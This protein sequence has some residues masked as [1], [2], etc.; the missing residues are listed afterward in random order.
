MSSAEAGL[1]ASHRRVLLEVARRSV[2]HG[3]RERRPLPVDPGA[4]AP[5]LRRH[6]ASFVTL[7]VDGSLRGCTGRIEASQPLVVDVAE[8]AGKSTFADPRFSAVSE[9]EL[10]QLEIHISVL[11]ALERLAVES[12]EDLVRTLRPKVDGLV[13][14]EGALQSTFLPSVW[15]SIAEA[16]EFVRELKRK[17]GL[18]PQHW[19][20]ALECFRYTTESI[21]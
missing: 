7:C 1:S 12:E 21:P 8:S 16:R 20:P 11:S 14:R 13:L 6:R 2:E 3:V 19:S 9:R 15:D 17:A 4:H 5:E 18:S 10:S